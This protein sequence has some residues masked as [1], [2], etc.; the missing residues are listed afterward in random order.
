[1]AGRHAEAREAGALWLRHNP[2]FTIGKFRKEGR[3]R[4]PVY[5]AQRQR[6][7]EG[8]HLAAMPE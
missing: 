8:L 3:G 7:A 1:L 4:N 2:Q 6:L 5:T